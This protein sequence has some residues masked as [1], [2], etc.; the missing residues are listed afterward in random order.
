MHNLSFQVGK[1]NF[2]LTVETLCNNSYQGSYF[3]P[4]AEAQA[5]AQARMRVIMCSPASL[6]SH[7]VIFQNNNL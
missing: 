1:K 6:K 4:Q 3:S 5:K 7:F 2:L